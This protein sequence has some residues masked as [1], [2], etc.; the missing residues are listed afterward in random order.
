MDILTRLWKSLH[1]IRFCA[2]HHPMV[3]HHSELCPV[4]E[5][6]FMIAIQRSMNA[7]TRITLMMPKSDTCSGLNATP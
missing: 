7:E 2:D 6:E 1:F 4:C 3:L 5:R